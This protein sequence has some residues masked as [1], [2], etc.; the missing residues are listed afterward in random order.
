M[1]ITKKK[2]FYLYKIILS[3]NLTA[4]SIILYEILRIFF[5]PINLTLSLIE[6]IFYKK[7]KT[8]FQTPVIFVIGSHRS[9]CTFVAQNLLRKLNV[10]GLNNVNNIF[11][12]SS[13]I[14]SKYIKIRNIKYGKLI[15]YY[16]HTSNLYD[17]NDNYQVWDRWFGHDHDFINKKYL[18]NIQ[19]INEYFANI[20]SIIN[21]PILSKNG[22]NIFAMNVLDKM[23]KKSLFI[24]VDRDIKKIINSTKNAKFFFFKNKYSWGLKINN[25]KKTVEKQCLEIKKYIKLNVKKLPRKKVIHVNYEDF[26]NKKKQQLIV[27]RIKKKIKII[28]AKNYN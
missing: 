15:N 22:R 4:Y 19:N 26:L 16:G 28:N 7:K 20:Y 18:N 5:Y 21:K 10:Y 2:F 17:V 14:I 9:G 27:R 1:L 24:I 6:N 3:K 13:I 23:F 12:K 25:K 8:N 11:N